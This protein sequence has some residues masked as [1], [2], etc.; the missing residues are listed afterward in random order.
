VTASLSELDNW[1][2]HWL[3]YASSAEDNPAQ[4]MRRRAIVRLLRLHGAGDRVLDVGSG[5]G[6]LLRDLERLYPS[7][8]LCGLEYSRA[9]VE[10][11]RRKV[12]KA[13][14]VQ[15]D[16]LLPADPPDGLVGWATHAVCSEVL[17]HV[18]DPSALLVN[19][20]AFMAEGCRMVVTVPGGPMSA[21]DKHIGHRRHFD[22]ASLR[23]L[24]VGSGFKVE[25]ARGFGFPFFNLY[26]LTV[27]ARGERLVQDV[28]QNPGGNS[29]PLAR[30]V[31][32]VFGGLFRLNTNWIGAGWQ[33]IAVAKALR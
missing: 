5:Q 8:K 32:R 2:R 33:V 30:N 3:D 26:R 23:E 28:A 24:L 18:D 16:L 19:A 21:F 20:R 22:P 12:P 25:I 17:E 15:R 10:M 11:S 9:G 7:A 6:D 13:T 29:S 4:M 27:I 14:F 1:D 31:M